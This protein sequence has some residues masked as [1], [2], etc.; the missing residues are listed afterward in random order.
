M[1]SSRN[2]LVLPIDVFDSY[3]AMSRQAAR[4]VVAELERQPGLIFCAS[5]GGTPTRLY[6]LLAERYRRQPRLFEKMR[7]LKIDEWGGV[8]P[9]SPA[10]CEFDLRTKLLD[11][12]HIGRDRYV[13]FR[14]EAKDPHAEC[15]RLA[16]QIS[17][18]GPIDICILGL[19]V[20]GHVAMNEPASALAPHVHVARLAPSSTNHTMLGQL[21]NKPRYGLTVGMTDILSSRIVLLLVNGKHKR[22]AMRRL[23][24]PSVTT[25]FPASFIWLHPR[26]RVLC[27]AEAAP[28]RIPGGNHPKE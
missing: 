16:Q 7:V 8:P 13:G 20:N 2:G 11:P 21:R 18:Q 28:K 9:S 24:T 4:L 1:I 17:R 25:Q 5:A 27:D 12:L 3:E 22:D 14:A 23:L 19:G 26:A 15:A 6:E 10:S